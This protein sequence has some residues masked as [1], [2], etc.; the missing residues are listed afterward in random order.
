[1]FY[2]VAIKSFSGVNSQLKKF[3]SINCPALSCGPDL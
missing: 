3:E 2:L 1:M